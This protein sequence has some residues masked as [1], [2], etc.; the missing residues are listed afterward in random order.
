MSLLA[1][2]T[3]LQAVNRMLKSIGQAPVSTL[4]VS[5]IRDVNLARQDLEE[6]TRDTL[7]N[8]WWFNTDEEYELTPDIDGKILIP[9][10]ALDVDP[11]DP[12]S[13]VVVRENPD[14]ALALYDTLNKTYVFTE[15]VE[16]KV[17]W[18]Y[19]FDG[20]PQVMRTYVATAA[21]R[22]FQSRVIGSAILDRFEQEDEQKAWLLLQRRERANRDTNI[23]RRN[24][25]MR[26]FYRRS[27]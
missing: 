4:A 19:T 6:I 7:V 16:C 12:T 26:R 25:A 9:S 20:L 18:G 24:P 22:R 23:F 3:E 27:Y 13:D 14:G 2:M 10:G 1:A 8:G 15:P 21:G 11:S 17:I 5:G